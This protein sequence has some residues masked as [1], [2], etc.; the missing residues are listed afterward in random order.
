MIF[1]PKFSLANT[2]TPVQKVHFQS[3]QFFIKRDD[4]TGT[5]LTGNKVRKLEYLLADAVKKKADIVVT[6]GG[7]QSNHA[8]ATAIACAKIGLPCKLYLW[9]TKKN[10]PTGNTFLDTV[11]GAE[12][13]Y[14]NKQNYFDFVKDPLA[15]LELLKKQYK[16]PYFITE[17]GSDGIG[18]LGYIEAFSEMAYIL[19]EQKISSITL[20]AGTGGTAAGLL[21]GSALYKTPVTIQVVNVLYDKDTL[22]HKIEQLVDPIAKKE[23]LETTAILRNLVILDGFSEEGYKNIAP[24][25]MQLITQFARETG[26]LLDPVYTGKAFYAFY[27]TCLQQK[28][29]KKNMFLHTGG[30]FG[31]FEKQ[32]QYLSV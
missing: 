29:Q 6:C 17:G 9:G 21:I 19:K 31:V 25:K 16:K 3:K 4:F 11:F 24:D 1:P 10:N 30:I 7:E 14:L 26:I 28:K 12:I 22:H 23:Q 13:E 20:A 8:R 2:P 18:I 5:E 15:D 27:Y 32:L